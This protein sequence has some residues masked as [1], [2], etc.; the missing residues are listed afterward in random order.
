MF[1]DEQLFL[2][3]STDDLLDRI[4]SSVPSSVEFQ[5]NQAWKSFLS[6]KDTDDKVLYVY[7]LSTQLITRAQVIEEY[8]EAGSKGTHNKHATFTDPHSPLWLTPES[9]IL[10]S[11]FDHFSPES[12]SWALALPLELPTDLVPCYLPIGTIS[13][14]SILG[15]EHYI[16]TK[17]I[18]QP[19]PLVI[20]A[21]QRKKL[22]RS[23]ACFFGAF[24]VK[25]IQVE[26]V[27]A[28]VDTIMTF[29]DTDLEATIQEDEEST[30]VVDENKVLLER[31]LPDD[32]HNMYFILPMVRT[33]QEDFLDS[34]TD[35]HRAW[36]EYELFVKDVLAHG[37]ETAR[38]TRV[39]VGDDYDC[40]DAQFIVDWSLIER[41]LGV[42]DPDYQSAD[43]PPLNLL[44]YI[45][46]IDQF[47]ATL[48]SKPVKITL[49]TYQILQDEERRRKAWI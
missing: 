45:R 15:T 8:A 48:P 41:C 42:H 49:P 2:E 1:S 11:S 19:K 35:V 39:G 29:G 21:T 31:P 46:Q 44:E 30:T 18:P 32:M 14:L 37:S 9:R 6:G 4:G 26:S 40:K 25:P 20:D 12:L 13:F 17:L 23:Q 43:K 5:L 24:N 36:Q 47:V 34:F 10:V 22:I 38:W 33:E 27:A 16:K 28:K 7:R 3:S